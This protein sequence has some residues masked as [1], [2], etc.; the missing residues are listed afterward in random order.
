MLATADRVMMD[1][2]NFIL[3]KSDGNEADILF[4][5]GGKPNEGRGECE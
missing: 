2:E 4:K 1:C 5:S 3:A